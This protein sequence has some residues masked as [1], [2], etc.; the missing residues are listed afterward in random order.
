LEGVRAGGGEVRAGL[1]TPDFSCNSSLKESRRKHARITHDHASP[2]QP[3]D[4]HFP[5]TADPHVPMRLAAAAELPAAQRRP[6]RL[7]Q[8]PHLPRAPLQRLP[9]PGRTFSTPLRGMQ[10][11]FQGCA[12]STRGAPAASV[13]GQVIPAVQREIPLLVPPGP[14]ATERVLIARVR[15]RGVPAA[16]RRGQVHCSVRRSS[17]GVKRH[18]NT[19]RPPS[20]VTRGDCLRRVDEDQGALQRCRRPRLLRLPTRTPRPKPLPAPSTSNAP[21]RQ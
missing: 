6:R 16:G 19:P 7:A 12:G 15:A 3:A 8:L 9:P 21:I 13:R 18:N 1:Y 10:G 11:P 17:C 4:T 2:N 14:L 20:W 5:S